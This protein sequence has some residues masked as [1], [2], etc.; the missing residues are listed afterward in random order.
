MDS[1]LMSDTLKAVTRLRVAM[2]DKWPGEGKW[3]AAYRAGD[4]LDTLLGYP[5]DPRN[6]VVDM[7]SWKRARGLA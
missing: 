5:Y 4:D 2:K 1:A 6:K 7:F 3:K